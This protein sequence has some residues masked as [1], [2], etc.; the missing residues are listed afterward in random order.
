MEISASTLLGQSCTPLLGARV[1]RF[2]EPSYVLGYLGGGKVFLLK[3]IAKDLAGFFSLV[4]EGFPRIY[5][6][7][8][9]MVLLHVILVIATFM[10]MV[11][12]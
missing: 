1:S 3:S 6:V 5:L 8:L 2:C 7:F 4:C 12:C 9:C 10:V 11:N